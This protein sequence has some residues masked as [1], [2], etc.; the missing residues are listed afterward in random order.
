M[1]IILSLFPCHYL[2]PLPPT[3]PTHFKKNPRTMFHQVIQKVENRL[4][5]WQRG[6]MSYSGR[7]LHVKT[8]LSS[9]PT[10]FLTVFKM[11]T[12]GYAKIDRLEEI[13]FEKGKIMTM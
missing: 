10:Y 1:N 8:I 3:P 7:E 13:F 9:L 11:P 5:D 2:T 6:I 12:L 4:H